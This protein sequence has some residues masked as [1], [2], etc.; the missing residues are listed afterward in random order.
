[1]A[2]HNANSCA[3]NL[4]APMSSQCFGLWRAEGA[5]LVSK[6]LEVLVVGKVQGGEAGGG[7]RGGCGGPKAIWSRPRSAPTGRGMWDKPPPH[8]LDLCLL[9]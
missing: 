3:S 4:M 1:M 7:D 5:D 9:L 6:G 2:H 8:C